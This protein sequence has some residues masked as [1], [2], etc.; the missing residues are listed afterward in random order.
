MKINMK[1]TNTALTLIGIIS[2]SSSSAS[3]ESVENKKTKN[4]ATFLRN[5][6]Q[7]PT[8]NFVGF[9][10]EKC[11]KKLS[12]M[13]MQMQDLYQAIM[14]SDS[15]KEARTSC[16]AELE[17]YDKVSAVVCALESEG[18]Y[19][20]HFSEMWGGGLMDAQ[21]DLASIFVETGNFTK[22][23]TLE[24]CIA[25]CYTGQGDGC[26]DVAVFLPYY[27][28]VSVQQYCSLNWS[29]MDEAYMSLKICTAKAIG[30][31]EHVGLYQKQQREND[32]CS[33]EYC[34]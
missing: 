15:Y 10:G 30:K 18:K 32:K 34:H 9:P 29:G 25:D 14:A 27:G 13:S 12:T 11:G 28:E 33:Y 31:E 7:I 4:T 20:L 23:S 1:I 17:I 24:S 16:A 26:V 2:S 3:A 19:E 22:L 8:L 21:Y 6:M 5:H